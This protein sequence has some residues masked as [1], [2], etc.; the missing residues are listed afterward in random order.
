RRAPRTVSNLSSGGGFI[1]LRFLMLQKT[2]QSS[3][4]DPFAGVGGRSPSLA[5]PIFASGL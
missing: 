3:P 5:G 1:A 4:P 2:P